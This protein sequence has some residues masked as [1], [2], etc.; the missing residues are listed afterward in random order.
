MRRWVSYHGVS[1]N[2]NPDLSHFGGIVPCGIDEFGVTSLARLGHAVHLVVRAALGVADAEAELPRRLM[3]ELPNF[4]QPA[5][6]VW[7]D[8][9]PKNANGKL[10]RDGLKDRLSA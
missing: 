7:L 10:D 1:I 9:F 3:Q 6:Y 8:E 4:M 5:D 2:L